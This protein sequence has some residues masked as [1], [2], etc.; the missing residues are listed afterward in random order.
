MDQARLSLPS[1]CRIPRSV[2]LRSG[3]KQEAAVSPLRR[4]PSLTLTGIWWRQ[5]VSCQDQFSSWSAWTRSCNLTSTMPRAT[6]S[7]GLD[8]PECDPR[9]TTGQQGGGTAPR[10]GAK[11][12][13][14]RSTAPT[15]S[16]TSLGREG[17]HRSAVAGAGE[18][19]PL[20]QRT[21]ACGMECP[22]ASVVGLGSDN[23]QAARADRYRLT[24]PEQNATV[25]PAA[26]VAGLAMEQTGRGQR[27][28]KQW[29]RS[30]SRGSGP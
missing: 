5:P 28:Q 24:T 25:C 22:L 27:H 9:L 26:S 10:A 17:R 2:S 7:R 29:P 6:R 23:V 1:I 16:M 12:R 20:G 30:S 8:Q 19:R 4:S 11:A 13:T 15:H 3:D 14:D 18:P 21:V